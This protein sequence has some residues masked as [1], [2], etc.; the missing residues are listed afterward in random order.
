MRIIRSTILTLLLLSLLGIAQDGQERVS[1]DADVRFAPL[2][3]MIDPT[4]QRMAAYQFELKA[5]RGQV[6]IVGVEGGEH[7][8]FAAAPFYDPAALEQD[9]IIVAAYNI[10]EN[11][12]NTK[13]RVATI[14]LQIVG[15][16]EPEY[17]IQLMVASNLEGDPI[18]ASIACEKG[19]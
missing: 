7:P 10:N 13:F 5:V 8:A 2:R 16:A 18:Q 3:I 11:L 1:E 6:K 4:G 14:H 12:P 19:E 15:P 9:R 17:E